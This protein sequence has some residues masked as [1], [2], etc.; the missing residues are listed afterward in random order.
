MDSLK[1]AG[2]APPDT[3]GHAVT[4]TLSAADANVL[5]LGVLFV[6]GVLFI[7]AHAWYWDNLTLPNPWGL[8]AA[9]FAGLFVHEGLHGLGFLLGGAR[10]SEVK[11][12]IAW[13]KLMLYTSCR[14][15]LSARAYRVAVALPGVVLGLLPA[16]V[17][18]A[19]GWWTWT[20]FGIFM[21]GPAA[22]DAAVLWAIRAVPGKTRVVDHPT[23]VGCQVLPS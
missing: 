8:C 6:S 19:L 4:M 3:A 9:F 1:D 15:P 13:S 2:E 16:L 12:G 22:G 11:F 14:V 5:A 17:G 20:L 23:E 18:L 10:S 21:I 7:G